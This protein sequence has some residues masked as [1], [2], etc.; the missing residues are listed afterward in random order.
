MCEREEGS[1]EGHLEQLN[2]PWY[3]RGMMSPKVEKSPLMQW[4]LGE[5]GQLSRVFFIPVAPP[6]QSFDKWRGEDVLYAWGVEESTN[7]F[8]K[9][10]QANLTMWDSGG[11]TQVTNDASVQNGAPS[12]SRFQAN[13]NALVEI[14]VV[15]GAF[16]FARVYR[17]V[18]PRAYEPL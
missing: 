14:G 5:D 8:S 18:S 13:G 6:L 16:T 1:L 9:A 11:L 7:A 17:K 10:P 4:K 2:I 15:G 12:H 3:I